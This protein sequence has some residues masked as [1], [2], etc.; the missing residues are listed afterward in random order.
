M[1]LDAGANHQIDSEGN[2]SSARLYLQTRVQAIVRAPVKVVKTS[3][4]ILVQTVV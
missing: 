4:L 1:L 2:L 3:M